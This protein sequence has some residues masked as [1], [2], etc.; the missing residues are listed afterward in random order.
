[1]IE[2]LLLSYCMGLTYVK[3]NVSSAAIAFSKKELNL[4]P[5]FIGYNSRNKYVSRWY[6]YFKKILPSW[7]GGFQINLK[8]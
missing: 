7:M 2:T 3:S 5:L 1:M 8:Y 6:W 4:H